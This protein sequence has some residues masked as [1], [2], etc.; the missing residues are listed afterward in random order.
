VKK[1]NS[2]SSPQRYRQP[3]PDKNHNELSL[4]TQPLYSSSQY[5]SIREEQPSVE[6]R[7]HERPQLTPEK[8]AEKS[9]PTDYTRQILNEP[10]SL[11]KEQRSPPV[12]DTH[13]AT[14]PYEYPTVVSVY[15]KKS[16]GI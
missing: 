7:Q 4:I 10:Q 16:R 6:D 12:Y 8:E 13:Y 15:D 5:D 2:L 11:Q 14:K 3:Q 9:S 1:D